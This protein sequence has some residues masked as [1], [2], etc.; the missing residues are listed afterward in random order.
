LASINKPHLKF[1]HGYAIVRIDHPINRDVPE[2]S[3]SVLKVYKSE[4]EAGKEV[5]RLQ[6]VNKGKACNYFVCTTHM[7]P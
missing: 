6:S 2:N 7:M 5:S 1:E 3:V 4:E